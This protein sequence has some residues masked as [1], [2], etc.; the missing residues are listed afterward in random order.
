[1][2]F[3]RV[4]DSVQGVGDIDAPSTRY[5]YVSRIPSERQE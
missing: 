3:M 1:M 2:G 4:I 5:E